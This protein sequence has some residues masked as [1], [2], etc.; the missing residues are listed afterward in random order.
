[1]LDR[2]RFPFLDLRALEN[3]GSRLIPIRSLTDSSSSIW[4]TP[5]EGEDF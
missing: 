5:E 3:L 4:A 1:M 2:R